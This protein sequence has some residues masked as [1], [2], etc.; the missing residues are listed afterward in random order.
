MRISIALTLLIVISLLSLTNLLPA[1]NAQSEPLPIA[2]PMIPIP[3]NCEQRIP[4][5][6]LPYTISSPG[7]YYVTKDLTGVA[8]SNGITVD[9]DDVTL[10]LNGF[11]LR[12][13]PGSGHGI[14]KNL[15]GERHNVR[16]Y[17]GTVREWGED[18]INFQNSYNCQFDDLKLYQNTSNGLASRN[19]VVRGCSADGN[20]GQGFLLHGLN[21]TV[22]ACVAVEN[23]GHGIAT[24]GVVMNCVANSNGD[25]GYNLINTS[26]VINCNA[27]GNVGDGLGS[28]SFGNT[29]SDCSFGS[30][31]EA[32]IR[33]SFDSTVKGCTVYS[34]Q[35]SGIIANHRCHI[36]GNL[37][38][39]NTGAG[40]KVEGSGTRIDSN[41]T[42]D[43]KTGI[44]VTGTSNIII[45]NSASQNTAVNYSITGGNDAGP[46][47]SAATA[48]SPWANL[49]F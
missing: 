29:I 2:G 10:D 19:A 38:K 45:R 43:N 44:E 12:G 8:G 16:I 31:T 17:N 5:S 9:A 34:N 6:S 18:G 23:N 48:T 36:V 15:I 47:G 20:G 32:G 14:A 41:N 25:D 1:L 7:S 27:N 30:N 24:G 42:V 4:I 3:I 49:Q 21:S 26:T 46:I 28:D 33:V 11:T 39:G 35:D 40:I 22:V 37:C 13:I